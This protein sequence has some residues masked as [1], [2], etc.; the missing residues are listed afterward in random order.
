[1]EILRQTVAGK[2]RSSSTFTFTDDV[3][4]IIEHHLPRAFLLKNVKNLLGHDRG[5]TFEVIRRTLAGELDYQVSV[6]VIDA[7]S[8]V[9]QHRERTFIV[10]FREKNGFSLDDLVV[11]ERASGPRLGSILHPED[12]SEEVEDRFTYGSQAKVID[13]YTLSD[14]LWNYLQAY[15][16]KH[17][18]AGN[19]FRFGLVGSNDIA[20]TLLTRYY[21]DSSEILVSRGLRANPRRLTPCECSRLMGFRGPDSQPFIIPVSDTQSYKQFGNAVVVPAVTRHMKPWLRG[22][23]VEG[24]ITGGPT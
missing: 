12:G 11:P 8:F 3:A 2:Q 13:K 23:R 21:K 16:A 15:A 4:R 14:K 7:R 18:A 24:E 6:R 9:P 22:C 19:G 17:K 1:M 10:G 20:R 5:R